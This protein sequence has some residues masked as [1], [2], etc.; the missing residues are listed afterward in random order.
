MIVVA[1]MPSIYDGFGLSNP[2]LNRTKRDKHIL[3]KA[4]IKHISRYAKDLSVIKYRDSKY[5]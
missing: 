5:L 4:Q 1:I 2:V 3:I